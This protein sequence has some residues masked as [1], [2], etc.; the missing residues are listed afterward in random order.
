MGNK[1]ADKITSASKKYN[2]NID[3]DVG[4]ASLKDVKKASPKDLSKKKDTYLQKK[5]NKLLIN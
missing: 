1:S 4:V 5:D 2:A 3:T